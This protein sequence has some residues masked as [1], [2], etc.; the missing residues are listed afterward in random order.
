[1][2]LN[3]GVTGGIVGDDLAIQRP[4]YFDNEPVTFL[5]EKI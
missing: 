1:M 4:T 5:S 2:K 3:K